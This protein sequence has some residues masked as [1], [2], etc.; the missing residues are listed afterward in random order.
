MQI[1]L[2]RQKALDD[3][4][5]LYI[6]LKYTGDNNYG[7][8]CTCG[9][10]KHFYELDC[11]HFQPRRHYPTR[12]DEMNCHIQCHYCN[13]RMKGRMFEFG[14]YIDRV[15][16]RDTSDRLYTKS[17]KG[18]SPSKSDVEEMI[19]YYRAEVRKLKKTKHAS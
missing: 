5:S 2:A 19:T 6:R 3:A 7:V 4:F 13:R 9:R 10:V 14:Q 12:W 1:P 15:Y 18:Q 17:R 16:G 8:C 11:G